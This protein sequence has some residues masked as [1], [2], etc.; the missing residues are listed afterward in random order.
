MVLLIRGDSLN[1]C[2]DCG[3][4]VTTCRD[5]QQ[6][7]EEEAVVIIVQDEEGGEVWGTPFEK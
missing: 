3:D 1:Y 4:V 7:E 6:E 5:K 2:S